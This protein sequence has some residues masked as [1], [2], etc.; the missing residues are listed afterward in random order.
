MTNRHRPSF[1]GRDPVYTGPPRGARSPTEPADAA[2]PTP[3]APPVEKPTDVAPPA[4]AAPQPPRSE[5]ASQP[6]RDAPPA[7][8]GACRLNAKIRLEE[9]A[10]ARLE[11]L[12][13]GSGDTSEQLLGYLRRNLMDDLRALLA[14]GARPAYPAPPRA[15]AAVR[16]QLTLQGEDLH[17]ARQWL[18]PLS[19]GDHVLRDRLRAVLAGLLRDRVDALAGRQSGRDEEKQAGP[20]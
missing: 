18:D 6:R 20:G 11:S 12:A 15:G 4:P 9:G 7:R 13:R 5:E 2:V 17:R 10:A 14:S 16:V 19:I 8:D 3:A 1:I